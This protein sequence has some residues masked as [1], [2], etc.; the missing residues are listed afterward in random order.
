MPDP[1]KRTRQHSHSG[2]RPSIEVDRTVGGATEQRRFDLPKRAATLTGMPAPAAPG[3][4]PPPAPRLPGDLAPT[5]P[6]PNPLQHKTIRRPTPPSVV[7]SMR[8]TPVPPSEDTPSEETPPQSLQEGQ[9][10]A[11][12]K[13]LADEREKTRSAEADLA[14]LKRQARVQAEA[15]SPASNFPPPVTPAA[16]TVVVQGVSSETLEDYRKAQTK[17]ML[18]F[19]GLIVAIGGPCALWLTNAAIRS[20]S[21][22]KRNEVQITEVA[23]A[24]ETTKEKTS[25]ANKEAAVTKADLA[26]FKL[27][28]IVLQ[29]R[30]GV[31]VRLPEGVRE[32]DLPKLDFEAPVRKPGEVKPGASLIVQTPP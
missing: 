25:D 30:Q 29:R 5:L 1:P 7:A 3:S 8:R 10:A 16:P 12:R 11:L 13:A 6:A 20:E 26:K 14:E 23:K 17:L 28:M 2:E 4:K 18:A 24:N 15:A 19:A 22:T 27:Y 9:E 21:T 32:E 31:W